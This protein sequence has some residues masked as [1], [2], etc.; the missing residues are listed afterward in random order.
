MITHELNSHTF[1]TYTRTQQS[2]LQDIDVYTSDTA[3]AAGKRLTDVPK[4]ARFL[5][6]LFCNTDHVFL[7]AHSFLKTGVKC[8]QVSTPP[9][10]WP[11]FTR[12][13]RQH[14]NGKDTLPSGPLNE[15]PVTPKRQRNQ[16]RPKD[17]STRNS[18]KK[19][20]KN[21]KPCNTTL[22]FPTH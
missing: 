20:T 19:R 17:K 3:S 22:P 15:I 2:P 13:S 11:R 16:H 21:G 4:A 9:V 8:A 5:E 14:C 12:V 1:K 10:A 18:G 7:F 6:V